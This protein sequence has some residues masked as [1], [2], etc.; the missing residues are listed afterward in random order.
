MRR[1]LTVSVAV[2]SAVGGLALAVPR[3]LAADPVGTITEYPVASGGGLNR[4]T[5][6]PDGNIWF[7]ESGI[8]KIARMTPAGSATPGVVTEFAIP[9]PDSGPIDITTGPD[10]ALWFT[11]FVGTIGRI[12]TSGQITE[13]RIAPLRNNGTSLKKDRAFAFGITSGP[14][15]ALWFIVNCCAPSGQ[16]DSSIGR[17]TTTGEITLFPVPKG[18]SP[19]VGITTGPDGNLWYPATNVPCANKNL[20]CSDRIDGRIQRMTPA[21]VVTGDFVIPSPYSDPS[22]IVTG[23]DG[24][25]WFTEQGAI[26]ANGCCQPSRP[27]PGKIGRITTAGVITEFTTPPNSAG[28]PVTNPA[29]IAAGPDGNIWWTEYSYL[30]RPR[31]PEPGGLLHGGNRIGRIN[32]STLAITEF[33]IPTAHARADGITAG[34]TGDGGLYFTESPNNYAD[35]AVGRIQ[36]TT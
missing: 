28:S 27:E 20:P 25:L 11:E 9:T 26:G 29:G 10:G 33:P 4:I 17:I 14:D 19:A 3:A 1:I 18:T 7:T 22:R 13:Y 5:S 23:S 32:V 21:G 2:V 36:A 24:N 16:P 12:T 30:T 8:N 34:P 6:G 35:S 31:D 15:G